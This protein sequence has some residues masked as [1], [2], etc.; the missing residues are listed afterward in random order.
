MLLQMLSAKCSSGAFNQLDSPVLMRNRIITHLRKQL[1]PNLLA[2]KRLKS[3]QQNS[4]HNLC[5]ARNVKRL[6]SAGFDTSFSW[7]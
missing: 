1:L 4:P 2:L 3:E 7:I 5:T 6:R